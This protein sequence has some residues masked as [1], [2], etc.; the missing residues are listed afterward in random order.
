MR[1]T[2][3]ASLLVSARM[4]AFGQGAG[5]QTPD[6]K[7]QF[8]VASV[9]ISGPVTP[10]AILGARGGPGTNDPG[11]LTIGHANMKSLLTQAFGVKANQIS[12][13]AWLDKTDS[14]RYDISAK[15]PVGA[16]KEDLKTMLQNLLVERFGLAFHRGTNDVQGYELVVGQNGPKL[17]E[18]EMSADPAPAPTGQ[19]L[20]IERDRNGI[21]QLPSEGPRMIID[22]GTVGRQVVAARQQTITQIASFLENLLGKP[23]V[24]RTGLTAKYDYG[25][26]FDT[27]GLPGASNPRVASVS[28]AQT[29][30]VAAPPSAFDNAPASAP[31]IFNAVQQELGLRLDQKKVTVELI[32]VDRLEKVPSEN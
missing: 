27:T 7:L 10:G 18:S 8:E 23:V 13:P 11:Q 24:D 4:A 6:P 2:I 26:A 14:D 15:V 29:A 30:G 21:P 28:A 3:L 25:F 32:V 16:S 19:P 9:K 31:S 22:A 1:T 17:K 20:R 5:A 12:G